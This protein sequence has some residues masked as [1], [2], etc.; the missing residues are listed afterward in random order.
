MRIITLLNPSLWP[1]RR[2]RQMLEGFDMCTT[3]PTILQQCL[4]Y[5]LASVLSGMV[6]VR[7]VIPTVHCCVFEE[8]LACCGMGIVPW[9]CLKRVRTPIHV[10]QSAVARDGVSSVNCGCTSVTHR[11]L[12]APDIAQGC[13]S[14]GVCPSCR[15]LQVLWL[16]PPRSRRNL[17]AVSV[18]LF[19]SIACSEDDWSAHLLPRD[20]W[21]GA[22]LCKPGQLA[23]SSWQHPLEWDILLLFAC[24]SWVCC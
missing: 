19:C 9:R 1:G 13:P 2:N 14:H 15:L 3:I 5:M 21:L 16:Q 12:G 17:S 10:H 4:R 22:E 6:G 18:R 20:S 11:H 7:A 8:D 24:Q 23:P